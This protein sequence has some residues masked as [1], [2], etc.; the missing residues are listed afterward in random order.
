MFFNGSK[1]GYRIQETLEATLSRTLATIAEVGSVMSLG[2]FRLRVWGLG[3][4]GLG[5]GV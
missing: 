3:F 2:S 1:G 5:I 4:K